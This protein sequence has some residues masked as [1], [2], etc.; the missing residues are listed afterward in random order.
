M[1]APNTLDIQEMINTEGNSDFDTEFQDFIRD[2]GENTEQNLDLDMSEQ[3]P[4]TIEPPQ[5]DC[6]CDPT[7]GHHEL[8]PNFDH[9]DSATQ[10]QSLVNLINEWRCQLQKMWKHIQ[11]ITAQVNQVQHTNS[12]LSTNAQN[13]QTGQN[14]LNENNITEHNQFKKGLVKINYK[15]CSNQKELDEKLKEM[16]QQIKTETEKELENWRETSDSTLTTSLEE[17][18][19]KLLL[20]GQALHMN[21]EEQT[22]NIGSS[23]LAGIEEAQKDLDKRIGRLDERLGD[24][25]ALKAVEHLLAVS[26]IKKNIISYTDCITF[27]ADFLTDHMSKLDARIADVLNDDITSLKTVDN[28]QAEE[29]DQIQEGLTAIEKILGDTKPE[30]MANVRDFDAK[31][32]EGIQTY[33]TSNPAFDMKLSERISTTVNLHVLNTYNKQIENLTTNIGMLSTNHT[34]LSG[35]VDQHTTRI[36]T[37]EGRLDR[38]DSQITSL[39]EKDIALEERIGKVAEDVDKKHDGIT[40]D[41]SQINKSYQDLRK[42]IGL[43]DTP[44]E[45]TDKVAVFKHLTELDNA[46]NTAKGRIDVHDSDLTDINTTLLNHTNDI[47]AISSSLTNTK[48]ELQSS[49]NQTNDELAEQVETLQQKNTE[50]DEAHSGLESRIDTLTNT[51]IPDITTRLDTVVEKAEILDTIDDV[52]ANNN[53]VTDVITTATKNKTDIEAINKTLEEHTPNIVTANENA[54]KALDQG[55]TNKNNIETLQ[56]GVSA[57]NS[58]TENLKT[59]MESAETFITE[60]TKTFEERGPILEAHDKRIDALEALK[61]GESMEGLENDLNGNIDAAIETIQKKIDDDLET[62]DDHNKDF[63][64]L[65]NRVNDVECILYGTTPEEEAGETDSAGL[66]QKLAELSQKL[67]LQ[68]QEITNELSTATEGVKAELLGE[69][70]TVKTQATDYSNGLI[71]GPRPQNLPA[72]KDLPEGGL[73]SMI[74]GLEAQLGT[75]EPPA[76]GEGG[77]ESG[78][79]SEPVV[80]LNQQ[81]KTHTEQIEA[82]DATVNNIISDTN[83]DLTK[84]NLSSLQQTVDQI[85]GLENLNLGV[86]NLN[87]LQ[88]SIEGIAAT[89]LDMVPQLTD[90]K[91]RIDAL[92][93]APAEEGGNEGNTGGEDGTPPTGDGSGNPD[94]EE[95]TP[96]TVTPP[97]LSLNTLNTAINNIR[98]GN[99]VDNLQTLRTAIDING[100]NITTINNTIDAKIAAAINAALITERESYDAIIEGQNARITAL[101]TAINTLTTTRIET[102]EE[103]VTTLINETNGRVP[104]AEKDIDGL[105]TQID[106]LKAALATLQDN[107]TEFKLLAAELNNNV[108]NEAR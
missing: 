6:S 21:L 7:V 16:N 69:I 91:N 83:L 13:W 53:A 60:A 35:K 31:L 27:L 95:T 102:L 74:K 80:P 23:K 103:Q 77:N 47:S 68:D 10:S 101:E 42:I 32:G 67:E 40:A 81:I 85:K 94:G 87:T 34:T 36:G 107:F 106:E 44:S 52:V 28:E 17:I 58:T 59:R 38:H 73:L 55:D 88:G 57:L 65:D 24:V 25:G 41:I 98:G 100:S 93:G 64:N 1:S 99:T 78:G 19:R 12:V 75:N 50:Q 51:T 14:I 96:P 108:D 79:S 48:N 3:T 62:K 54:Q 26:P 9:M 82:I 61:I 97:A 46:L 66:I 71:F 63:T 90:L 104:T 15:I 86:T 72:D 105:Q 30:D 5:N 92:M 18:Q 56:N 43:S 70:N 33:I 37:A 22:G 2:A 89:Q 39:Q 45:D 76:E 11:S 29:I 4:P 49:I 84:T 8:V 20:L